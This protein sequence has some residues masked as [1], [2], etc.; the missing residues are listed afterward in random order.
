MAKVLGILG[1]LF[2]G[3][4]L[5][6]FLLGSWFDIDMT[7]VSWSPIVLGAIGGILGYVASQMEAEKQNSEKKSE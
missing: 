3:F 5:V 1:I 4:A 7:G 2:L 6:D